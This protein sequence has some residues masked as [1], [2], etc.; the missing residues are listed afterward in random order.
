M[1]EISTVTVFIVYYLSVYKK[2]NQMAKVS[3]IAASK[4]KG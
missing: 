4:V 2:P 3:I 1:G